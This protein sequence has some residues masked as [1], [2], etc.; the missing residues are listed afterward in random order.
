M[1]DF[2]RFIDSPDIREYNKNTHFTPAKQ[3]VLISKSKNTTVLEKLSALKYL[4]KNYSDEE[5][6]SDIVFRILLLPKR[7]YRGKR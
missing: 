2:L 4:T 6:G 7:L 1:F 3:A 5:F